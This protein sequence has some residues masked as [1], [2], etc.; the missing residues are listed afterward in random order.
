MDEISSTLSALQTPIK[1]NIDT[2]QIDSP[3]S[4][5]LQSKLH[6][7]IQLTGHLNNCMGN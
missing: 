5:D 6:Y 1:K 7:G 4:H 3:D 2:I